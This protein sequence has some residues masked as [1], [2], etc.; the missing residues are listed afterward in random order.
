[1]RVWAQFGKPALV[2]LLDPGQAGLSQHWTGA[3][4]GLSSAGTALPL[5]GEVNLK[6]RSDMLL[7]VM[8]SLGVNSRQSSSLAG[9]LVPF[10]QASVA[11]GTSQWLFW[12]ECCVFGAGAL[13]R[14]CPACQLFSVPHALISTLAFHFNL[15]RKYWKPVCETPAELLTSSLQTASIKQWKASKWYSLLNKP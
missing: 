5:P 15:G 14:R 1:M 11:G 13:G 7:R 9:G 3:D 2:L 8:F 4:D 10:L 12:V 6:C